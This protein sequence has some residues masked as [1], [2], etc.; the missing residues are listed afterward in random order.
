MQAQ[1]QVAARRSRQDGSH[2]DAVANAAIERERHQ[3]CARHGADLDVLRLFLARGARDTCVLRD[4]EPRLAGVA[5]RVGD[6]ERA[7]ALVGFALAHPSANSS[8]R[9]MA[10]PLLAELQAH[11][12]ATQLEVALARGRNLTLEAA[13]TLGRM[14]VP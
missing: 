9:D 1:R 6:D 12:H 3:L 7:A 8:V 10:E 2:V 4:E 11:M 14:E 13:I 5:R